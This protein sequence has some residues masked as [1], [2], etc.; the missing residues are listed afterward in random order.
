MRCERLDVASDRVQD[1]Q[2]GF[3][4]EEG[5]G[6]GARCEILRTGMDSEICLIEYGDT[7]FVREKLADFGQGIVGRRGVGC[8]HE[9]EDIRGSDEFFSAPDTLALDRASGSS[10]SCG[11]NETEGDAVK[12]QSFLDCV[13][14]SAGM[15]GNDG[16]VAA[17]EAVEECGFAY[18]RRSGNSDEEAMPECAAVLIGGEEFRGEPVRISDAVCGAPELGGG[19]VL[20]GEVERDF[21]GGGSAEDVVI[22]FC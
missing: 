21:E 22:T 13:P 7:M 20:V 14:G 8:K 4:V 12:S 18:I 11:V 2:V 19:K 3:G 1:G 15:F 16:A 6:N 10:E 5:R 17:E 9:D